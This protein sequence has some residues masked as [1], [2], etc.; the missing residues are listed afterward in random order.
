MIF[1]TILLVWFA[2]L[3]GM[4]YGLGRNQKRR[5]TFDEVDA[6]LVSALW[7]VTAPAIL[8]IGFYKKGEKDAKKAEAKG[9]AGAPS[10]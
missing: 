8:V 10:A 4:M 7:P 9:R 2:G 1:L 3:A 5:G 6:L